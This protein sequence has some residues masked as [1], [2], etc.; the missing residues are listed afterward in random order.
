MSYNPYDRFSKS[1]LI[2]RDQLAIDRTILANERTL[3]SY[4]RGAVAMV[5]AGLTFVQFIEYGILRYIGMALVPIGLFTGVFGLSR[6]RRINRRILRF[7]Q[8]MDKIPEKQ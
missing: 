8:D 1:E 5:I 4:L 7:R 3:L 6:Y 2:L